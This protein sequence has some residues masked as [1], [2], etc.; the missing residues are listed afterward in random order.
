MI[1]L[2]NYQNKSTFNYGTFH[3]YLDE[4]LPGIMGNLNEAERMEQTIEIY[5][6]MVN[7][8]QLGVGLYTVEGVVPVGSRIQ[9]W[10]YTSF[11][12]IRIPNGYENIVPR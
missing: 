10:K 9:P 5:D 7:Q 2:N 4:R 6:W 3:S 1:G 8:N 11:S 12:D